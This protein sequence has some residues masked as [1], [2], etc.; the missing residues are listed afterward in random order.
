MHPCILGELACGNLSNRR[1]TL[2]YL[3]LLPALVSAPDDDVF[4][5]LETERLFGRGLGWIDSQILASVMQANCSL[6]TLDVRLR[7]VAAELSV[8]VEYP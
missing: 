4:G 7:R 6:W 3:R 2:S 5:L 1:Q 8:S